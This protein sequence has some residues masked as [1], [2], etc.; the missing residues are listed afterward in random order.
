MT[1]P[2]TARFVGLAIFSSAIFTLAACNSPQ[3]EF[4]S[5][6]EKS[7]SFNNSYHFNGIEFKPNTSWQ[8]VGNAKISAD[9]K[10]F[11]F[12]PG[13]DVLTSQPVVGHKGDS[14][15]L[16]TAKAYQDVTLSLAV[17]VN[18]STNS[19]VYFQGLYRIN[20]S[21]IY[22]RKR[23]WA[24]TMGGLFPRYDENREFKQFD[25]KAAKVNNA[26]PPGEWQQ[27]EIDFRAPRFDKNGLKTAYAQFVSVKINDVEVM[28]NQIATGPSRFAIAKHESAKA[29]MFFVG[30]GNKVAFKDIKITPKDFSAVAPAQKVKDIDKIP[31]GPKLGKPMFNL[32]E[33]GKKTFAAKGCKEC[34]EVNKDAVSVKTGPS[35]FGIFAPK[36][37]SITVYDVAEQHNTVMKADDKYLLDSLRRSTLH[38]AVRKIANGKEKQFLPIMPSFNA[39]AVSESE[40]QAL[41]AYLQS[42]ND[43]ENKGADYIWQE[44]PEKPYVLVEDLKAELVSDQPRIVRVNIGDLVSGRAYHVG[45]PSQVNYSFDPRTLAIEMIWSGRFLSLKNE[46]LGRADEAS[47]IGRGAKLWPKKSVSHLFQPILSGG[48]KVDFFFKEPNKLDGDISEKFLTNTTDF[49]SQLNSIDA[50]FI[51]VDTPAGAIPRFN[52]QVNANNISMQLDIVAGNTIKANFNFDNKTAQVL[53]FSDSKL[54]NI[55]VSHGEIKQGQWLLPIGK[56]ANVTFTAEVEKAPKVSTIDDGVVAQSNKPQALIW[57]AATDDKH[58]LPAGY[59]IENALAPTDKF[60][61]T[62]LFEPLGIDFTNSGNAYV[63]TRTAGVWKI[64]DNKW[65]QFAEGT[66]D[67]LGLKVENEH[68]IMVGEKPGL[69]RMLDSDQDGWAEKRLNVSDGFRFNANYHEYL[70]GPVK[71]PNNEYLYTLNLGHGVPNGYGGGGMKT[72]GGYRGWAIK[73]DA[74][75]NE[76]LFAYGLRSPAGVE[77]SPDGKLYYTENQGDFQGTSKLYVLAKDN[78]YGHA[79]SLV[80]LPNMTQASKAIEWQNYKAK[81]EL[82]VALLPHGRA[83]NSPGHPVWDESKGSFGPYQGQMFV[84]DQSKS[85]I[86]RVQSETVNGVEQAALLP[87]MAFTSS[88]AMRLAFSPL[89]NS[90]WIGQTGRGW[91]AQGG[92]LSSLQRIVWDGKT[93]PQSIYTISVTHTGYRVSFT[94]PVNKTV[95]ASFDKLAISSWYYQEDTNY[96][97]EEYDVRNENVTEQ[98]WSKDGK[99]L[100][101]S[102]AN[103]SAEQPVKEEFTSRVYELDLT[104]TQF[105]QQQSAFH[106]KAWYTLHQ[107]PK[108]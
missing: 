69:T 78:Y 31:L 56:Y 26:K 58:T 72:T 22:G 20:F 92:N 39:E 43:D 68:S 41:S 42:L 80:D 11:D 9:E 32:V 98:T 62:V 8:E 65:Q 108:K 75:G 87:F 103:F 79:A 6:V 61:R 24:N 15:F 29:P 96:G 107:V 2:I 52:Y 60:G 82:P 44:H 46:K 105:A 17:N 34:H 85:N 93:T 18:K 33:Q 7:K 28:A 101:L 38:L 27:V 49:A 10:Y 66:F 64:T 51:G 106:K 71:L 50:K 104:K 13:T 83:M 94:Q 35:L 99:T 86:F 3:T 89:D 19:G 53:S 47:A 74:K 102:L 81:R 67:S 30:N 45:L 16:E 55:K 57:T 63:S 84:G 77:L 70:H 59:R 90:M 14:S 40:V 37:K 73:V 48:N 54:T 25:G 1:F 5:K 91:W 88:G 95:R 36:S 12:Q 23:W 76:S 97:S 100:N 4:S 21:D